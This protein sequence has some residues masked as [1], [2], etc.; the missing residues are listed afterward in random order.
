MRRPLCW[1]L[2]RITPGTRRALLICLMAVL[3]VMYGIAWF[4]P[5]IGLAYVDGATLVTALTHRINTE[6]PLFPA[7]LGL[8]ALVSRQAWWLKLLPLLCTVAWLA[9]AKRLLLKMGATK[10]C[11]WM[12]VGMT[13]VS[14]TVLYL[15]TNLFGESLFA[16]LVTASLIALLDDKPWI[17]GLCAGL[18]TI[19]FSAGAT[20]IVACLL[21]LAANRRFRSGLIFT[22]T[23]MV[24]AAPWLGWSFAHD[25]LSVL[26]LHASEWAT[27]LGSNLT[28][29]AAAPFTLLSGYAN[30]YPGLLTAVAVMIVLIKRRHFV[31]DLFLG[32]YCLA[33]LVRTEPPLYAFA[34]VLPLFLW[35]LWRGVRTGRFAAI[36]KA[37]AI[38]MIAPA[39]WFSAWSLRPSDNWRQME[40]LF[41]FIR[42]NTAPDA[43]LLA[44]LDPVF[45]LNTGRPTVRSFTPG[46]LLRE[47]VSYVVLTPDGDIAFHTAVAAMERGGL[48]EPVPVPGVSREYRVLRVKPQLPPLFGAGTSR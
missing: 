4:R 41:A 1:D 12:L 7:L 22:G 24:F 35:V 45:Y 37:T 5:A 34:P 29:L 26:K 16:L 48:I 10:E 32:F 39:L 18:A 27:L 40:T 6:P 31:P 15:A 43:V 25:G 28:H 3:A 36:T 30:L 19:T 44:D 21:T 46:S 47:H 17:A 23:A 8:F 2:P 9:L 38:L 20:L 11:A 42:A 33:L 14:P 13:V